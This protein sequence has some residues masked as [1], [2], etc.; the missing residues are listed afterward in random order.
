[1]VP[2]APMLV[3]GASVK[4]AGWAQI[5][6]SLPVHLTSMDQ[7]A[8]RF[9]LARKTIQRGKDIVVN[10]CERKVMCFSCFSGE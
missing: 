1:M 10:M 3:A 9:V 4:M 7:A 8:L 5:A 2:S 6:P